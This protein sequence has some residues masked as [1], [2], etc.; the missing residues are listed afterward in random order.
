MDVELEDVQ[1]RGI[2]SVSAEDI[3][4]ARYFGY[5]MK[6]IG[7]AK[8]SENRIEVSVGPTLISHSHPLASVSNEFNAVYVYGEAVGETMFYGPG[9]GSLPTA[10]AIVSDLVA[11]MKNM[12]LGVNGTSAVLPQYPKELKDDHEIH[13]KSF[14]RFTVQ[15]QLGSFAKIT[16]LFT[17]CDISFEKIIQVPLKHQGLAEIILVTHQ[18]SSAAFKKVIRDLEA[19]DVVDEVRSYYRIA[20]EE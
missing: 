3:D 5:T 20:G 19:S 2:S 6:L 10:T 4:Y 12:R 1:V 16:S 11:V 18:A 13:F 8:R 15:D 7:Y 14:F 17:E 9:A